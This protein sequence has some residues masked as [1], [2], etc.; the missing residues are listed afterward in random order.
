[1]LLEPVGAH[2]QRNAD[3][4]IEL[5]FG[6]S[7]E[8]WEQKGLAVEVLEELHEALVAADVPDYSQALL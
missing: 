7:F 6:V 5:G 3:L 8:Q 1:M 4:W 2:E